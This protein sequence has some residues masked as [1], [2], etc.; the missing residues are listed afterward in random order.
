MT[1]KDSKCSHDDGYAWEQYWVHCLKKDYPACPFCKPVEPKCPHGISNGEYCDGCDCIIGKPVEPCK[2]E[3]AI[4]GVECRKCRTLVTEF[5][6]VEP[7]RCKHDVMIPDCFKC[8]DKEGNPVEQGKICELRLWMG[9][10][11]QKKSYSQSQKN[12]MGCWNLTCA[13]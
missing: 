11:R 9:L 1:P 5:K 8:Y 6:P 4:N 3:V 2:H 7:E 12:V 10:R 13:K